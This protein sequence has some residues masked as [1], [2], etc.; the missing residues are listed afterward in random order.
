MALELYLLEMIQ[1]LHTFLYH[2]LKNGIF[3]E[4]L[5]ERCQYGISF[6]G[7][8]VLTYIPTEHLYFT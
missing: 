2:I 4:L 5:G 1:W 8:G 6:L 7:F 3:V